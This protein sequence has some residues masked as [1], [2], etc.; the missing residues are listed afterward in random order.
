MAK[1][2][3]TLMGVDEIEALADKGYYSA[4]DLVKCEGAKITTYVPKL[5]TSNPTGLYP[6]DMFHY[7]SATD[8]YTCPGEQ[9]LTA[10]R[11]RE[12]NTLRDYKNSKAC[13]NC[14]LR[15]LCTTAEKGR[16]ITRNMAQELLDKI[17]KRT[18]ANHGKYRLR[19]LMAEHPFGT[20]KRSFGFT[21]FLTRGN[22]AARAESSLAFLMY[23]ITRAIKILGF[24]NIMGKLA[25]A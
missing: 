12:E 20:V 24:K 21:Y 17:D 15:D 18:K 8:T 5:K 22:A 23:N 9:I 7:N 11:F 14:K 4:A 2:A 19:Q 10:G 1:S 3:K 6:A 25:T 13:K 16:T